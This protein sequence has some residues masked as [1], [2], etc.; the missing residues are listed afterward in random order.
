MLSDTESDAV[1]AYVSRYVEKGAS[2]ERVHPELVAFDCFCTLEGIELARQAG[3]LS[4]TQARALGSSYVE[5]LIVSASELPDFIIP[6]L[7]YSTVPDW[8]EERLTRYAAITITYRGSDARQRLVNNVCDF[9]CDGEPTSQLKTEISAIY[10][11]T[12]GRTYEMLGK[13]RFR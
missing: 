8:L 2:G 11:L 4:A 9:I 7:A 13:A 1:N 6:T 5:Q 10:S 12:S 3:K